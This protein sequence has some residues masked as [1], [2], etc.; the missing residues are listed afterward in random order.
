M[1]RF[2]AFGLGAAVLLLLAGGATAAGNGDMKAF[3]GTWRGTSTC[4][5]RTLAPACNDETV[6]YEVRRAEKPN[7]VI[8]AAD[9]IVDGKRLPMGELEFVSSEPDGCW[10]GEFTTPRAHGVWCLI[11]EGRNLHGSLLH[12]PENVAVRKVQAV[13][14]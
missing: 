9:K 10:R 2:A 13:H 14:D 7:A 5:N 3:L 11:V 12:M 8:L 6:I 1:I 4:V